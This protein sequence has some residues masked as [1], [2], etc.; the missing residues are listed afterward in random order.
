MAETTRDLAPPAEVRRIA[1]VL[2]D[3]GFATWAVGGAVRDALAG[4]E[5]GD[6]DL[7]TAAP[8]ARV[9]S[10]FRRTVPVGIEHGTVGVIGG[11][12]VMYEVTTFRRDIETDGRRARV[13]FGVDLRD[14]LDRRD[15]TINAVAW[16]PLTGEV[17]DPHGGMADLRDGRLRTVGDAR[18]RFAE[19][20][21][22]VLRA[23]RFAGRFGLRVDEDT[24]A[25]VAASAGELGHLSAERVRDELL[26]LLAETNQASRSLGLY[27]RSGALAALF[28][29]LAPPVGEPV[30]PPSRG[31]GPPTWEAA[32][33]AVDTLPRHR[34]LLRVAALL[35]SARPVAAEPV[36]E[37]SAA[38]FAPAAAAARTVLQRLRFSRADEDWATHLIA[39]L[40][41]WPAP[42][43]PAADLRRWLQRIGPEYLHD[44][45]RLRVALLRGRGAPDHEL[46]DL[47]TLAGRAR[48]TLRDRPPLE[49]GDLAIDGS[50]LRRL[51]LKPGP[52]YGE[53]LR[54]L[55]ERVVEEPALNQRERLLEIVERRVG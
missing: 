25:A 4:L 52:L 21:L 17:L 51:G 31:A 27:R 22:R 19:D 29:E 47:C 5:P 23:L 42:A 55:L 15:F 24:W 1:Q 46:R 49:V 12:G 28:P 3:A 7:A 35:A 48:A 38:P 45:L 11:D 34:T 18:E 39:Q 53:I 8:P 10:L 33:A 36:A 13:S 37:P 20:R 43:A 30:P 41:A 50:D 32:L 9:R 16:H 14:D 26:K 6:W 44:L 40:G 2:E 54:E